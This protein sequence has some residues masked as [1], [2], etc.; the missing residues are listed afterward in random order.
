MASA[1]LTQFRRSKLYQDTPIIALTAS[2][3]PSEIAQ[4]QQAG[5]DGLIGKP[6]DPTHLFSSVEFCAGGDM[7][8]CMN[9]NPS[10]TQRLIEILGHLWMRATPKLRCA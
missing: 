3:T 9:T 10:M 5:F 1:L 2:S 6:I 8:A 7:G 4:M